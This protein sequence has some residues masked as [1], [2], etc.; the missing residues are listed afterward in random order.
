MTNYTPRL[1]H[2]GQF[3][4]DCIATAAFRYALGRQ[5]GV[6]DIVARFLIANAAHFSKSDRD[7][8]IREIGQALD[9]GQ[10]GMDC[11]VR[12]W[13]AVREAMRRAS[14]QQKESEI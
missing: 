8:Y 7:L 9:E 14:Q 12:D 6:V 11:D 5:T 1:T 4:E 10:A 13:E 2:H 3:D